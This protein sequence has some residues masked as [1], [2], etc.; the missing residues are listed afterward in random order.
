VQQIQDDTDKSASR[1]ANKKKPA[2]GGH[3]HEQNYQKSNNENEPHQTLHRDSVGYHGLSLSS[4]L[5]ITE[6]RN[7]PL[8]RA[9]L[10][11]LPE[12]MT[13]GRSSHVSS[14]Q[15]VVL[16]RETL[17]HVYLFGPSSKGRF[18]AT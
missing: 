12:R 11:M 17:A 2:S 1:H 4:A 14:R 18:P 7:G 10:Y 5:I 3:S 9:W 13:N 16:L 15:I 6:R 8:L